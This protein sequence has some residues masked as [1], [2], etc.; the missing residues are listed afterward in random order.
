MARLSTLARFEVSGEIL[1]E[2]TVALLAARDCRLA[3]ADMDAGDFAA[4]WELLSEQWQSIRQEVAEYDTE[5]LRRRWIMPLLDLLGHDPQFLKSH[6][7]YGDG[8]TVA[9]THRS[10]NVPFWLLGWKENADDRQE[11]GRRKASPHE[12]FQEYLDQTDDDWGIVC[13]GKT[14]RLLHDYHKTLTRN[15]VEAD[16][17]S[18]FEALDVDGF[19]AVWRIFRARQFQPDGK[20]VLP[21]EKLRDQSRQDGA[22]IG[23]ELRKQVLQAIRTLGNGFLAA[24][25]TGEL[26]TSLHADPR[27]VSEFYQALLRIVYRLLFLLYIENKP[28]WTPATSPIWASSYSITRLREQAEE[29]GTLRAEGEDHW[30]G[31]RVVFGIIRDGC[32]AF[33]IH[34]YGG[35]LF[36]DERLGPLRDVPLKNSDLLRAIWLLTVFERNHQAIRVNFR[37]LRIDA[38]GSV[39]EALLDVAPTL[40]AE[41]VFTFAEG[42]DRKLT[43]S[44]YTPPELVAELIGSALI[45]V[46][47]DRLKDAVTPADQEAALLGITVVDSACGSG[48]FLLQ[49]MDA[50]AERLCLI[51]T[52]GEEPSDLDI[53]RARRDV[54]TH[55]IHGVDLNPMA[56]ELCKFTLWLHVAHPKLPL[57]YLEPLIKC[58]NALVGVPLFGQVERAKAKIE[59]E[60][61]PL[62][63]RGDRMA[64]AKLQYIGWPETLPDEAFDPVAGD[65]KDFA[66]SAKTRNKQQRGGQLTL[67]QESINL[68]MERLAVAYKKVTAVGDYSIADVKEKDVRYRAYQRSREY[69][70][71]KLLADLWCAAFYWRLD[72]ANA[73]VP[74]QE[75]LS[76]AQTNPD[77]L[78]ETIPA[79]LDRITAR[80]RPFHWEIEFPDVFQRGGFDCILGNPPWERIK[81]QEE[82]F[83]A[84]RAPEIAHAKNKAVRGRMIAELTETNPVLLQDFEDAKHAAECDSKFMRQSGRFPLTAVGDINTYALFSEIDRVLLNQTGRAGI[85]VPTGIATDDTTKVFF[86]DLVSSRSLCSLFGF[87]NEGGLFPGVHHAFKFVLLTIG[88]QGGTV[89]ELAFLCR[90][91]PDCHDPK[92]R[93]HLTSDEFSLINPNTRTCP[94][95]RTRADADLTADIYG[96]VPILWNE[97][98]GQNPWRI[99]FSAMFHMSNN[100]G[101][102]KDAPAEDRFPLYEAKMLHQFDHRWGTYENATPEQL[103]V[104]TLPQPTL[105]QKADPNFTVTPRYWVENWDV[106]ERVSDVPAGLVVACRKG[107]MKEVCLLL[108]Q[109]HIAFPAALDDAEMLTWTRDFIIRQ[110]PRWLM[111]FR[112]ITSNVVTRTAIFSLLPLIAV[113]NKIPILLNISKASDACCLIANLDSIVHDYSARQKISGTTLNFFILK[114]FPVLPPKAYGDADVGFIA[115]RVLELV[116]TA[117]E[118]QPFAQ[119]MG[120]DGPPFVWNE[121]RRALLLAELD[122]YYARLY[123]LTRKQLRYILDPHGL[124]DAE[125]ADILD[126][127]EDPTCAGPHLLPAHPTEDFPG[128][129]FRVLKNNDTAKYGDFRTRR[130]VLDAWA[131]LEAEL[132]PAVPRNYHDLLETPPPPAPQARQTAARNGHSG[133]SDGE[134]A[135]VPPDWT[136][137]GTLPI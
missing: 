71:P 121:E 55:C 14:I 83:F 53:R 42:T 109:S 1:S 52:G 18:I 128:E 116:Y 80:V 21:I 135:L 108:R 106:W 47:E 104:G 48:A 31:L 111:G 137:Q 130:L 23:K 103:A 5:R 57:S 70:E 33:G 127:W 20:G 92:R 117:W 82:E 93:F 39:Y 45:P 44:Y 51:R 27:A 97:E 4:A 28:G 88:E 77:G 34:P 64:A 36:N 37:T 102:F 75:W 26:R 134:F 25:R 115:P 84:T 7:D 58:G 125:L 12:Q 85:I 2:E 10:R 56:V 91:V 100:S 9:L 124:S 105:V 32:E 79:E 54:M 29:G 60:R 101:L 8:R 63:A 136:P 24:D 16:L 17:E 76:R 89:S 41:G 107:L 94:V 6:T 22:E 61:Q 46:I 69:G 118:M 122:A 40:S 38:L 120:Y 74:T 113:G 62:L 119:D 67:Q 99:K 96:R 3:G 129:T 90:Y 72:A 73:D 59:A 86:G 133:V 30:E 49:A 43:G 68:N 11:T 126:P 87:E 15:Y 112:D 110:C 13:N 78:P 66:K 132:G 123:G 35:E 19:R 114:Q 98:Q 95:F 50:L 131:R 65:A 81:L